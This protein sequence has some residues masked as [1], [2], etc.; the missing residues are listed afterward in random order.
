MISHGFITLLVDLVSATH[1]TN[2]L[3]PKPYKKI[4]DSLYHRRRLKTEEKTKVVAV[5]LGDSIG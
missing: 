2:N 5:V 1:L 3:G 4:T